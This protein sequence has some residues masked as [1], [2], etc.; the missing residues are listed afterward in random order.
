LLYH[1]RPVQFWAEVRSC[2]A[3]V[4]EKKPLDGASIALNT[5]YETIR[6]CEKE[7]IAVYLNLSCIA[8][9][10]A[11]KHYKKL[12]PKSVRDVSIRF[13]CGTRGKMNIPIPF[14]R[15]Q[16]RISPDTPCSIPI[17]EISVNSPLRYGIPVTFGSINSIIRPRDLLNCLFEFSTFAI[18][19][20]EAVLC[21][22]VK[23]IEIHSTY[24]EVYGSD[25]E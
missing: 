22:K 1:G 2:Y 4:Y 3:P 24:E 20:D 10:L 5:N 19:S 18:M 9:Q 8:F 25:T 13:T 15:K 17:E 6:G 7:I 23:H 14:A 12:I 16:G 21:G 11:R